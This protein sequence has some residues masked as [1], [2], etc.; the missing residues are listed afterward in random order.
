MVD[1][2]GSFVLDQWY[3]VEIEMRNTPDNYVRYR[4]DGGTWTSWVPRAQAGSTG[5][6]WHT[7]LFVDANPGTH[8]SYW[9]D[10]SFSPTLEP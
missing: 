10:F 6:T 8:D 7:D 9:D 2:A 3:K 4:L 5:G 1:L